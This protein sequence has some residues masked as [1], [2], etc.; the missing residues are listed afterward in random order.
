MDEQ[1]MQAESSGG[2]AIWIIAVLIIAA[3]VIG[4][5]FFTRGEEGA[6]DSSP[7]PSASV[8]PSASPS[9]S[10]AASVSGSPSASVPAGT[11]KTFNIT[12]QPFS[13]SLK[14]IRVKRGDRVKIVFNNQTGLHD[15]VIDE[16]NAK[17]PQI[18][19]GQMAEVEFVADKTGT[20]EYY[21]SVGNHRAMGMVGKLIV[22]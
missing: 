7:T 16:F 14:E 10:P 11:V 6:M 18:Q 15:W 20:F 17:T 19:A 8:S 5:I 12:G 3:A 2:K 13:F 4:F 9:A 1:N 22:E 21:C